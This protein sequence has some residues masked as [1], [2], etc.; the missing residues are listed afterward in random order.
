[1]PKRGQP[2]HYV[3][4]GCTAIVSLSAIPIPGHSYQNLRF[5][6][7]EALEHT[8][9]RKFRWTVG[10]NRSETGRGQE[11]NQGLYPIRQVTRDPITASHSKIT[12][13]GSKLCHLV[14]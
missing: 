5:D 8:P 13:R 2:G 1:M 14:Y 10:P 12:E 4:K 7:G 11:G 9:A 3:S 6:L